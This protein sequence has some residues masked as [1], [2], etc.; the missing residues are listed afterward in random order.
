MRSWMVAPGMALLVVVA[1]ALAPKPAP[2]PTI[3]EADAQDV[4]LR[5]GQFECCLVPE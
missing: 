4:C 2:A 1:A 3:A 5:L